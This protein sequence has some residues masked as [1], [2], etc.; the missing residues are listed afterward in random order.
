VMLGIVALVV[1]LQLAALY[2]PLRDLLD[3]EPLAAPD[4]ALCIGLGIGFVVLLEVIKAISRRRHPNA[5]E[6]IPT[7]APVDLAA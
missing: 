5:A 4:L 2:T 6:Q 1:A 3:L 7:R